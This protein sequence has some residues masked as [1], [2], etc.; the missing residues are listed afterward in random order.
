MPVR[1]FTIPFE[2]DKETFSDEDL[3]RFLLNKVVKRLAPE[4]F[5]LHDRAYWTVFIEY[6]VPV[7]A[8][9]SGSDDL[10]ET[11]KLQFKRLKEWRKER[12]DK[13]G[14][15]AFIIS[16]NK[17]LIDVIRRAPATMTALRD[18]HGFGKKKIERYGKD[19]LGIVKAFN[20]KTRLPDR[21][22]VEKTGDMIEPIDQQAGKDRER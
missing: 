6:E 3:S 18:I 2:P 17:Q 5:T 9:R 4:F 10:S 1:I 20:G 22:S 14:I 15:P 13:E 7:D 16:N 11:Q 12:A 8:D 19:I 21:S